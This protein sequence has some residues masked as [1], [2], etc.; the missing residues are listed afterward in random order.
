MLFSLVCSLL[1]LRFVHVQHMDGVEVG[2]GTGG[3]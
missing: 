3:M 2:G 1:A